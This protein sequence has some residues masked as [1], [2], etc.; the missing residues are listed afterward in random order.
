MTL[1]PLVWLAVAFPL[2]GFLVNGALALWR[3]QAK[4]AVS[5][6]GAGVLLAAFA[7]SLGVFLEEFLHMRPGEELET[8]RVDFARLVSRPEVV[9][10]RLLAAGVR[11][12]G[13]AH[14]VREHAYVAVGAIKIRE[15]ERHTIR[16]KAG[17]EAAA[18]LPGPRPPG[19]GPLRSG[20]G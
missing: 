8:H 20:A 7:V 19:G 18:G 5:L 6:V 15:H 2:A 13:V 12:I 17:A 1:T 14:F 11:L 10:E 4:S 9:D 3:P 16:G